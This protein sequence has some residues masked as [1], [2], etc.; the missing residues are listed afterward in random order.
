MSSESQQFHRR[1][2]RLKDFSYSQ[3]GDY[4]VTLCTYQFKCIFGSIADCEV[5]LSQYGEIASVQWQKLP[6]RFQNIICESVIIMPNHI[7]GII[8]I[9]NHDENAGSLTSINETRIEA[10]NSTIT[11]IP[12]FSSHQIWQSGVRTREITLGDIIGAF[13]SLVAKECL[14]LCKSHNQRM[15]KLWQR[16]YYEKIIRNE[17]AYHKIIEYIH[18]NPLLWELDQFHQLS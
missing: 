2:I 15:G 3:P 17:K 6:E 7:H 18:N 4:F 5:H 8:T 12:K 11:D 10:N 1:S 13:K 9:Q 14:E 16:N